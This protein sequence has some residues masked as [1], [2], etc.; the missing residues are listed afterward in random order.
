MTRTTANRLI[1]LCS[2]L[3]IVLTSIIVWQSFFKA[4]ETKSNSVNIEGIE[5]TT[6]LPSAVHRD[7]IA[8]LKS[9][10]KPELVPETLSFTLQ[11]PAPGQPGD[12]HFANWNRDGMFFSFLVG[13][14]KDNQG[15]NYQRIWTM[16]PAGPMDE[17]TAQTHLARIFDSAFLSNFANVACTTSKDTP[18]R[19]D[20][21]SMKTQ[22]SGDLLGVTVRSPFQLEQLPGTTPVPGIPPVTIIA[23]CFVPKAGTPVY[24]DS[25][26]I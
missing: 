23:A 11:D 6:T 5:L 20:C 10:L 4:P 8:F 21:G 7:V 16:P 18:P 19:T 12:T 1:I 13:L 26:C 24:T 25:L 14:R 3:I 15:L 22:D 17:Q 9:S 2:V